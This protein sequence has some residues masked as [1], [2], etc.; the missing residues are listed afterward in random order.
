MAL[1]AGEGFGVPQDWGNALDL[2]VRSAELGWPL[3]QASLAGLAGNWMF[4]AELLKG[5][6]A[7]R[8][9]W[10]SM[11]GAV[12]LG[13]WFHVPRASIVS[14]ISPRPKSAIG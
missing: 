11:R 4:A 6:E 1:H 12:D 5:D 14:R 3:A 10:K 7:P 2:L 9:D 8:A 13:A